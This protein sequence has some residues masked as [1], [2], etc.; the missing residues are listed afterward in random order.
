MLV[1]VGRKFCIAFCSLMFSRNPA[2]QLAMSLL[3]MFTAFTLQ[4]KVEPY[5]SPAE[6]PLTLAHHEREA[7]RGA[8]KTVHWRIMNSIKEQ[9]IPKRPHKYD[10]G[11]SW[12]DAGMLNQHAT[13]FLVNYNTIEAVLLACAVLVNLAGIMFESDRFTGKQF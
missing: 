7:A 4:V 13:L 1:I 12:Q 5:M 8:G 10:R 9:V 11:I 2:F 6:M 3:V